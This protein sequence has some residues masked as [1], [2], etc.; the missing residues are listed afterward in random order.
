MATQSDRA[1]RTAPEDVGVRLPASASM[2]DAGAPADTNPS[3]AGQIGSAT[4]G[5]GQTQHVK[6]PSAAAGRWLALRVRASTPSFWVQIAITDTARGH[7]VREFF[8]GPAQPRGRG[9]ARKFAR[10]F[11]RRGLVHVPRHADALRVHV[12]AEGGA[13]VPPVRLDLRVLSRP[14]AGLRL[15]RRHWRALPPVWAGQAHGRLGRLRTALGLAPAALGEPPPYAQWLRDFAALPVSLGDPWPGLRVCLWPG[16][17]AAE[18]ATRAALAAAG[19]T[20]ARILTPQDLAMPGPPAGTPAP[21]AWWLLLDAGEMPL[22]GAIGAMRQAAQAHPAARAVFGD[23]DHEDARGRPCQ[24][25]LRPPPEPLGVQSGLFVRG[26]AAFAGPPAPTGLSAAASAR[27]ALALGLPA[28]AMC[29]VPRP[30]SRLRP[31]TRP[32]DA[33]A[34]TALCQH[35]L[36]AALPPGISARVAMSGGVMTALRAISDPPMLSVIIPSAARGAHVAGCLAALAAGLGGVRHEIILAVSRVEPHDAA[37]ALV[38]RQAAAIPNLRVMDLAM[39]EFNYAAVNNRA[40][41]AASGA[42]LL[43]LND[44]VALMDQTTVPHMLA[45][46]ADDM[47]AAVGARLFYGHGAVQH[48]G[49]IL[50]LGGLC[51]HAAR[52]MAP[53]AAGPG[54]ILIAERAVSAVT[55]ACL[56]LR[57]SDFLAI[58]GFDERFAI[59]LNDVDLCLRLG[60]ARGRILFAAGARAWHYEQLSLG[61]HYAGARALAESQEVG[62]LRQLHAQALADDPWYHPLASREMGREWSPRFPIS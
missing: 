29:R 46:L 49:V 36:D 47:V 20:S 32:P 44:D 39:G 17:P 56:M 4:L 24:P 14:G 3:P 42:V 21:D 52:L 19:I 28:A 25:V 18:A 40:A 6:L 1:E 33:A 35:H 15:L 7:V 34:L 31:D 62:L 50:G 23:Y 9:L 60:Q 55:A 12:Y 61:R 53:D 38:L 41:A 22:P 57:R 10:G 59:A 37:Q 5:V 27:L 51:E 8:L 58:G 54:G 48:G 45:H 13:V 16:T 2:A 11:L 26:M 30:L 43:L